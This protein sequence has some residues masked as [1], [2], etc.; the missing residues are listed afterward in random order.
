MK[1][2]HVFRI[3]YLII[4][5]TTFVLLPGC[6]KDLIKEGVYS[7][8]EYKGR[9]I[10]NEGTP[11]SGVSVFLRSAAGVRINQQTTDEEGHFVFTA[12]LD[13]IDGET[14]YFDGGGSH[15][16]ELP[17]LGIGRKE[18]DYQDIV[19]YNSMIEE[20]PTMLYR[21][22]TYYIFP[23]VFGEAKWSDVDE[24]CHNLNENMDANYDCRDWFVPNKSELKAIFDNKETIGGFYEDGYWSSDNDEGL[25]LYV[26]FISG[27]TKQASTGSTYRVRLVR[28]NG[29]A[30]LDYPV[31]ETGEIVDVDQYSAKY[32]GNVL[33]DGGS[34]IVE[35]GVCWSNS[36]NPTFGGSSYSLSETMDVGNFA[37]VISGLQ[38]NTKYYVRGYAKNANGGE[39]YGT[40]LEFTTKV[41]ESEI[42]VTILEVT[43]VTSATVKCSVKMELLSGSFSGTL[44]ICIDTL[45]QPTIENTHTGVGVSL[46]VSSSGNSN[47]SSSTTTS[48]TFAS[49][50]PNTR[51]YIRG[52]AQNED[53]QDVTYGFNEM[54]VITISPIKTIDVNVITSTT[55]NGTGV[56]EKWCNGT[57][58]YGFCWSIT[59]EPTL[60]DHHSITTIIHHGVPSLEQFNVEMSDLAHGV[61]YYARA[62]AKREDQ[63]IVYY[64]EE[65]MFTTR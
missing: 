43:D 16:L 24:L 46:S 23:D 25:P 3:L 41:E 38:P 7:E 37:N 62:Y 55:A 15:I 60:E 54:V 63:N 65:I 1:K 59:P 10:T 14:I 34:S 40:E 22:K 57:I 45:P 36:P 35:R 2:Q 52:Y 48:L 33:S 50:Q 47:V 11:V 5:L 31:V 28:T 29:G 12:T 30:G 26:D 27:A 53:T 4:G 58:S 19:L 32:I 61:N 6:V 44:G 13:K 56:L 9:V 17:L 21:G 18:Y 42:Q 39:R 51:Y 64:G 20:L 8:T 49:L